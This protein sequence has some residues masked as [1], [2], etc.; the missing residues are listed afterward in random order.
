[1]YKPNK[2][3]I[4]GFNI[5]LFSVPFWIVLF[6]MVKQSEILSLA[7]RIRKWL[8]L[9]KWWIIYKINKDFSGAAISGHQTW[10]LLL[11]VEFL[12]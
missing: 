10:W 8:P 11:Y 6:L 9:G 7:D 1:M 5:Y 4:I 3:K 2:G 12:T